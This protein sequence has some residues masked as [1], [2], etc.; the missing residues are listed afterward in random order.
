MKRISV[1]IP[2]KNEEDYLLGTLNSLKKQTYGDF[3][4][5]VK[6]GL[7]VNGTLDIAREYADIVVSRSDRSIGDARNQGA[8]YATGE[9]FVF[10]DA[11]TCI[12]EDG[13]ERIANDFERYSIVLILPRFL[14]REE[15]IRYGNR[16]VYAPRAVDHLV[17]FSEDFVRK[18]IYHYVGGMCMP[19]DASAFR[20][21]RGFNQKLKVGEDI[22][23]SHRL[24]R[25]GPI[26]CDHEMKV[27]Y[28]VRRY[29]KRGWLKTCLIY[30]TYMLRSALSLEHPERLVIR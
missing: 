24:A 19:C 18:H 9:I 14:P 22:E 25:F 16:Y 12:E 6:D 15:M 28:S 1:I 17:S 11:D 26:L 4:I 8:G 20:K 10:L 21:V 5:I 3:E 2:T 29:L 7:S 13:L 27:Y 23:L 30:W